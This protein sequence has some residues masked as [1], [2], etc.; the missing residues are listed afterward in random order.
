MQTNLPHFIEVGQLQIGMYVHLDLGWMDHP[1]SVSNF[2][3]KDE[4]QISK[5]KKIGLKKLRYDPK[6]SDCEPLPVSTAEPITVNAAKTESNDTTSPPKKVEVKAIVPRTERLVQLNHAIN[7][8]EKKFVVA[9]NVARQVTHNILTEPQAS[10]EQANLL[11]NDMVDTALME[12]DVAI[13]ALNG[14]CSSDANYQHSLNVTV[15]SLMMAKSIEM[16]KEDFR[17]LGMAA[18]FHDIGKAEIANTVLMKKELLTKAE[19]L[20]Q[21]QHCEIGARMAQEVGLPVRVGKIILQHHEHADGTGYP[22]RLTADHTDPLAKLISLANGFDNLCNTINPALA[23]S[24]YEALAYMYANQRSRFDE[25]LLKHLIRTLGIYPPGSIVHLSTGAYAIV[26]SA[27][28]NKPLRPYV[29]LHDPKVDRET[30]TI[31]DL[32]EEPNINI[33]NCVRANQLPPDVL[34][35]LNPRKKISYFLDKTLLNDENAPNS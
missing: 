28:P 32:R 6:R 13:H 33:S 25:T 3:L 11:V 12:G 26:I 27:N 15:L 23:R 10:I 8:N 16:S 35:Y 22:K 17:L 31:L 14:N 4:E 19:L 18:I 30:P 24:P 9:S 5:I 20:H 21:E 34:S 29:M 7:E 2:K 1:F